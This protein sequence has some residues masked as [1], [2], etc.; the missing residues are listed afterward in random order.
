MRS[1]GF[2][3]RHPYA[4]VAL[5]ELMVIAVYMVAGT[6]AH[7]RHLTTLQMYGIANLALTVIVALQLTGMRW[8]K[9]TGFRAAGS[10]RDLRWYLVPLVPMA[11]NWVP[12]IDMGSAR[13]LLLVLSLTLMVGFVEEAV[14]RGLMFTALRSLGP[15]RAVMVPSVLFGLTHSLNV[16]AGKSGPEA[17]AQVAYAMAIGFAFAALMV[18]KGLLWPLVLVHFLIDF[19]H[20]SQ[21][22]GFEFS[23]VWNMT[24]VVGITAVFTAYGLWLMLTRGAREAAQV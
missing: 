13:H 11:I 17:L 3:A 12:G 18:R 19:A 6:I 4:F 21:K 22:P 5:V 20:F 23:P 16:L 15:W 9:A 14:F 8:W 2:A 7:L 24:I 1:P 10:P